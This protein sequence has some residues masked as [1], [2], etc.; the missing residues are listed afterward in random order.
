MLSSKLLLAHVPHPN[1]L[2]P[3]PLITAY[4]SELVEHMYPIACFREM[5]SLNI[6]RAFIVC[7]YAPFI[8]PTVLTWCTGKMAHVLNSEAV[9]FKSVE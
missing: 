7:L 5:S 1:N 4:F 2:V 3:F 6:I 9:H 8:Y